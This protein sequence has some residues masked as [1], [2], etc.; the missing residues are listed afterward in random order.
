MTKRLGIVC[1]SPG[2]G[3]L[4]MYTLQLAQSLL[5]KEWQIFFLLN[6]KSKLYFLAKREFPV[7]SIQEYQKEKNKASVIKKWN[8]QHRLNLIFTPYNKDIKPLSFY[9]RFYNRKIKL[10]YQQHMKVGVKKQDL[11]HRLRYNMLDL[12]ITPLDYL[13]QE[14]ITKTTVA[15]DKIRI[16]PVGLS[17]EKFQHATITKEEAREKLG[18]PQNV[19]L[20]GI[21]GRI[22]P[23][24]GQDFLIKSIAALKSEQP[25]HLLIMGA[26]TDHEGDDW[27][28]HLQSLIVQ[29]AIKD[30]IHF[31]PYQ[32]D[33]VLFYKAID[34]F[35]M[36]SHGETYGLVTLEA[37]YFEKPVIG[38][39]TDGTKA[40]LENGRLGWLHNPEDIDEFK[41]Q[42]FSIIHHPQQAKE[43]TL[44]ARQTVMEHYDFETT[45]KKMN[46]AFTQLFSQ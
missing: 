17:F 2:F 36:P 14:T 18:L 34:V 22:D 4:E 45:V 9:K 7:S 12:W 39:N 40:L 13:K 10:I 42:L 46:T 8:K 5:K 33:V 3:G 32:E 38:V 31:R 37:L 27:M 28:N 6:E 43:K 19:F 1:T 16:I 41:L 11:I 20:I 24:K 29:H 15:E 44:L 35:A 26:I 21:L 25:V 23:K 30:H